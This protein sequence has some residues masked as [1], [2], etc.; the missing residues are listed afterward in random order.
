MYM[1]IP[2]PI[3]HDI[4]EE[5]IGKSIA[6]VDISPM[7]VKKIEEDIE[8]GY[9]VIH[10]KNSEP[11]KTLLPFMVL[12]SKLIEQGLIDYVTASKE[13]CRISSAFSSYCKPT[14][15]NHL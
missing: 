11:V 4:T 15:Y 2:V 8:T 6:A 1:L 13:C 12:I 9:A 3:Y 14:N 10:Y 7:S 5:I